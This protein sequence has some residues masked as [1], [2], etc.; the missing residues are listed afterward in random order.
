MKAIQRRLERLRQEINDHNYRYYVLDSPLIS[1]AEYDRLFRELDELEHQYPRLVT[2]DSPTQRVGAAPLEEFATV[3]HRIPMLSLENAMD[4]EELRAF[5]ERVK[6]GLKTPGPIQYVAEPKLDGVA[7]ELVYEEGRLVVGSTRGDGVRGEDITQNLRTVWAVPLR[8]RR[9]ENLPALLEVRGEVF[10]TKEG[11]RALNR[12]REEAGESPFANPRNAAAGSLRQLDPR[13]T[14]RRPLSI[15][16]YQA[17]SVIGEGYKTHTEFLQTLQEWGF[18][19]N[20]EIRSFSGIEAALAYHRE[21]EQRRPKLPY[22]IDGTVIKINSYELRRALGIRSRSPRWAIAGKFAAQQVTTLVRDILPS[23]GRTGAVT[24]VAR[25]EP[26]EVGGVTVTHATL[27]NQDEIDRK[28]VRV[29]DTVLVQRAGEV[30]PEVVQVITEKRAPGTR[31]YRLPDSCP[32]CGHAV[33]RPPGE[34]VARCQN[35]SCPAQIKGRIQHFA[36]KGALDMDGLGEKLVDQLVEKGILRTV[37][38]LFSLQEADLESLERMGAKS[39]A[40]VVASIQAAKNTTP[41]RFIYALGIRQVGEHLARI[42]ERTFQGRIE[43]FFAATREDLE[44]IPEVGPVVAEN[45]VRF[46]EDKSNRA[47]VESCLAQGLS[48]K[49]SPETRD[50][51]LAGKRLVFTGSL[52]TWTRREAQT[53]V[54]NL[55]GRASGSLSKNTDYLVA[56]EGGGSKL[57]KARQL[58]VTVLS[59]K[60]FLE[61]IGTGVGQK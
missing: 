39:A 46:W 10:I 47:V 16:C 31:P 27:H 30:I 54:K 5:D 8:L 7:V 50:R 14:A 51:P 23:V 36:S 29:G 55:G 52:K 32:S 43:R 60:D 21:M 59:E 48:L 3:R 1:D 49:V 58:G 9:R 18:P 4:E 12:A 11:F 37:D 41:A 44:V 22:E 25:L 19:V 56:G 15:Y 35:L 34:A 6:K 57:G 2:P 13:I 26:V 53:L 24:P 45:I 42:L 61:L 28:D 40:N 33:Q 38:Q 20:P 17:G